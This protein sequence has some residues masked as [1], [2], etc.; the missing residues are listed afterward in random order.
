MYLK[1]K[2]Q[3][4]HNVTLKHIFRKEVGYFLP[5]LVGRS[6]LSVTT[7]FAAAEDCEGEHRQAAL[8]L[9]TADL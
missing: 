3:Q 6:V 9:R 8:R 7:L 1:K 2:Q 5:L 4:Q